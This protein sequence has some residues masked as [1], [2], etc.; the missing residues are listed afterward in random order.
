MPNKVEE[1]IHWFDKWKEAIC[2]IDTS[3]SDECC[4]DR[5]QGI[6]LEMTPEERDELKKLGLK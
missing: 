4:S 5:L 2:S 3:L 6:Y 1:Y